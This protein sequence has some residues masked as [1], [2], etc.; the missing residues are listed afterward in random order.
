VNSD[1]ASTVEITIAAMLNAP[2][3][4]PSI[5]LA[6]RFFKIPMLNGGRAAL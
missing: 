3:Y 6:M 2:L 5:G 4:D 1:T